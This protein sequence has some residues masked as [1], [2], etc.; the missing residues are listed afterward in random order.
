M[1][2][3]VSDTTL[4]Y[5]LI[6]H[7]LNPDE[8]SVI[9]EDS[10][11]EVL[12][13][14]LLH[15]VPTHGFVFR[16]KTLLRKIRREEAEA[17]KI[18]ADRYQELKDGKDI[19]LSDGTFIKNSHVT[20]APRR[21]LSYAYCSD[22]GFTDQFIKHIKG[23]DALYHEATFMLEKEASAREKMHATTVDAANTALRAHA[24]KLIIGHFS[25][26]Y[27]ELEPVLAEARAIFP[28]SY[29]AEEGAE[30]VLQ[31]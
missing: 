25:A 6:F 8:T 14:P 21:P 11:I 30:F 28:E 26:R 31:P 2:I 20:S 16:E 22:T 4:L 19:S 29:L 9:F 17:L 27:D 10:S 12:A 13:F 3:K 24:K 5:P 15:G 7:P 18:P 1:Q 23:V